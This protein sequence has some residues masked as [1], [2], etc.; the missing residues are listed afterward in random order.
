MTS[1]LTLATLGYR[2][3]KVHALLL[4][5]NELEEALK[6][7]KANTLRLARTNDALE[8]QLVLLNSQVKSTQE[9]LLPRKYSYPL[10]CI[11]AFNDEPRLTTDMFEPLQQHACKNYQPSL[12]CYVGKLVSV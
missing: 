2:D 11:S 5:N 4:K 7:E 1:I 10:P 6:Q 3:N 8:K 9:R 12:G